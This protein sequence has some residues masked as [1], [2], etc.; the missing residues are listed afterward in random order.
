MKT[1]NAKWAISN[2]QLTV[3]EN[4]SPSSEGLRPFHLAPFIS[5]PE[6]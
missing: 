4:H 2:Y 5:T 1:I 6:R 3:K